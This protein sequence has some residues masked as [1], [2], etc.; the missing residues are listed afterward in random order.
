[1]S[2][3]RNRIRKLPAYLSKF[4]ALTVLKAD[5][6]PIEWPPSEVAQSNEDL[7]DPEAM[8]RWVGSLKAWMT[9]NASNESSPFDSPR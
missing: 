4:R 9:T 6:N 3:S 8:G 1:M 5:H 2:I 7:E